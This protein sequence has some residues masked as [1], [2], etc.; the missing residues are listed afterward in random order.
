MV[1]SR[2]LAWGYALRWPFTTFQ[3]ERR[4]NPQHTI[5]NKNPPKGG[6]V[7]L[8][9]GREDLNLH[10]IISHSDLNAARLP[11]RHDRKIMN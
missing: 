7:F 6:L 3:A 2:D 9:C 5:K 11:F 1:W 10:G 8:W 4:S